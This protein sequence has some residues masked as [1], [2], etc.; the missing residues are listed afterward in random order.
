MLADANLPFLRIGNPASCDPRF[1]DHLIDSA[2]PSAPTFRHDSSPLWG[3]QGKC[4]VSTTS[5]LQARPEVLSLMHFS[6]CIVDEASQ[7]LEP[8]IIGLLSSA[9]IDRFVLVGDHKQL[10]AVVTQPPQL[11][12]VDA[13]LLRAIALTDCRQSL[14]ERLSRDALSN[15][16]DDLHG[17]LSRQG[18]MHRKSVA[19]SAGNIMANIWASSPCPIRRVS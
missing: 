5:M 14:F 3:N 12:V 6:L 17:L 18:R 16:Y 13:P 8:S 9:A 19:S 10:P 2:L 4:L 15:G 7:I 1:R 11:S